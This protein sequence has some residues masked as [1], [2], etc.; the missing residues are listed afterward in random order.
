MTGVFNMRLCRRLRCAYFA[1]GWFFAAAL[2]VCAPARAADQALTPERRFQIWT[3]FEFYP[4]DYQDDCTVHVETTGPAGSPFVEEGHFKILDESKIWSRSLNP[5]LAYFVGHYEPAPK[6]WRGFFS[7]MANCAETVPMFQDM[8]RSL[9]LKHPEVS[10]STWPGPVTDES[11]KLKNFLWLD[12]VPEHRRYIEVLKKAK[13]GCD[14]NFWAAALDWPRDDIKPNE[15]EHY[16]IS[17]N[18]ALGYLNKF[19]LLRLTEDAEEKSHL[20]SE[21]AVLA[22]D[23]ENLRQIDEARSL[24]DDYIQLKNCRTGGG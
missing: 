1:G 7:L 8:V 23:I 15:T 17:V 6:G 16:G 24:V 10:V 4:T 19:L 11:R 18:P 14:R 3:V 22:A 13:G 21:L 12:G 5:G 2:A 9:A 20:R